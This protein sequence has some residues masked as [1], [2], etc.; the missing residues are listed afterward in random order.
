MLIQDI[1]Q[2]RWTGAKSGFFFSRLPLLWA[3]NIDA[4]QEI[5]ERKKERNLPL[6]P[7]P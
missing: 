2:V 4:E 5:E 1:L 3:T 7:L 6:P